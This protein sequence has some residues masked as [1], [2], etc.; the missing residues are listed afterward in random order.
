M[1]ILPFIYTYTQL[2]LNAK[3]IE[4][5]SVQIDLK[6]YVYVQGTSRNFNTAIWNL[7]DYQTNLPSKFIA[8]SYGWFMKYTWL[9]KILVITDICQVKHNPDVKLG[10][11]TEA[12]YTT[13]ILL[14]HSRL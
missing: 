5:S 3:I 14:R 8:W 2:F 12:A 4:I 10:K 6:T 7:K 11:Q 9:W 1:C 13:H